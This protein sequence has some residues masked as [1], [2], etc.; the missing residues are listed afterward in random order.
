MRPG[1][2][3]G[4]AGVCAVAES[5]E[6]LFALKRELM[7]RL[8]GVP[9]VEEEKPVVCAWYPTV[10]AVLLW[11][12]SEKEEAFTVRLGD[13]RREVKV[14]GLGSEVVEDLG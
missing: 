11:N 6:E 2:K 13:K 3:A 9:V 8:A 14:E 5:M 1:V 7:P 10:R 4:G 12:L